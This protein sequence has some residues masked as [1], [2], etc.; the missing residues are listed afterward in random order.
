MAGITSTDLMISEAEEIIDEYVGPQDKFIERD[1][2]GLVSVGGNNAIKLESVHQNNMQADYLKGCWFE[3][4]GGTGEGQRKKITAQTYAGV[5]TLEANLSTPLDTTSYYRIWQ[6]GKFPRQ[7]DVTYDGTNTNKYYKSIPE[8]VRRTV[9]AQVE[10]MQALGESFFGSDAPDKQSES[11][12]D[13]SY[14][15]SS[16]ANGNGGGASRLIAPKAKILLRGI[17]NRLGTF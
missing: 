15:K 6:L 3:V 5:I 14:T 4:I 11:I 8:K 7:C 9:A 13:Y 17:I 12:G 10:Y 16:G 1:L 2:R